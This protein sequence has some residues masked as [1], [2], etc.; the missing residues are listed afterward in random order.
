MRSPAIV[1]PLTEIAEFRRSVNRKIWIV[2]GLL[3]VVTLGSLA[4]ALL[5]FVRP[6][7]V[8]IFD[9][10]GRPMLFSDT[11][12]PRL[13]LDRTRIEYFSQTFLE[14]WVGVD[15]GHVAEDLTDALNM[16]TPTLR[17]IVLTEGTEA[18]RR[19]QLAQYN[20]KTVFADVELRI[21]DFD[22]EDLTGK[23][24]VI[25]TGALG[26]RPKLGPLEAGEGPITKYFMT[27]LVLQ[28]VPIT[29]LSIHGLLVDYVDT[30]F[31]A[32]ADDLK[33]EKL[34]RAE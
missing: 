5:T 23:I 31:F 3:G 30:R 22:P 29:R 20:L 17:E 16:M 34:K 18:E 26:F 4:L 27:E 10:Q 6:I 21:S 8:V 25:G 11:V 19:K 32:T 15:S 9:G 2:I 28:R 1:P 13:Q 12:T 7:P 14:T 24:Y 33:V